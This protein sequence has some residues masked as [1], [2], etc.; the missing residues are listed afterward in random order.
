M[1]KKMIR[2]RKDVLERKQNLRPKGKAIRV[3]TKEKEKHARES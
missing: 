3:K 2:R 1:E